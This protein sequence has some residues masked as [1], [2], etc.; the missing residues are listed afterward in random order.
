[1]RG[2]EAAPCRSFS[3]GRTGGDGTEG[4]GS[5][6]DSYRTSLFT[7]HYSCCICYSLSTFIKLRRA[8]FTTH[9][10]PIPPMPASSRR[11]SN[12]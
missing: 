2:S 4:R 9:Y 12:A 5:E 8:G 6:E 11:C 7:I 3:V 10:S 1:M